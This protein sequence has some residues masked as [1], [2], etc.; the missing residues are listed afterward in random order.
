MKSGKW[1]VKVDWISLENV[2]NLK[3][4]AFCFVGWVELLYLILNSLN[5][6][7]MFFLDILLRVRV[8]V[9]WLTYYNVASYFTRLSDA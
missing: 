4:Y 2:M 3:L 9:N 5:F 8:R 7:E 6:G 1:S